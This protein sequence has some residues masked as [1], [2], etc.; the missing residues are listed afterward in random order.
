MSAKL[1]TDTVSSGTSGEVGFPMGNLTTTFTTVNLVNSV[2]LG[3]NTSRNYTLIQN[4]GNES[5]YIN[6]GAAASVGGG[7]LILPG[8][9][10]QT[11]IPQFSQAEIHGISDINHNN[12]V[13]YTIA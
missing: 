3:T 4:L 12:I 2:L 10:W 1:N 8:A 11:Q 7:L 9:T 13:I 5:I 6:F